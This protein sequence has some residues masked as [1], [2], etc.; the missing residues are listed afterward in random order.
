[1]GIEESWTLLS[2]IEES[3]MLLSLIDD[4]LMLLRRMEL[5]LIELSFEAEGALPSPTTERGTS[6][7]GTEAMPAETDC[8]PADSV[9]PSNDGA[10]VAVDV[11]VDVSVGVEVLVEV[12]VGDGVTLGVG[13]LVAVLVAQPVAAAGCGIGFCE[14]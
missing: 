11:G 8:W 12:A 1:M 13:V 14:N 3:L 4:S 2:S 9:S 6:F 7:K 5:S 10:V